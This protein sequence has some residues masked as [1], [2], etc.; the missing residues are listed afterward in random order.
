M[1]THTGSQ[2]HSVRR[3]F[4][5][6]FA[7]IFPGI[8][9]WLYF[10]ALAEPAG[11]P[12]DNTEAS[13]AVVV[14]YSLAK[15][16]QFGFPLIW[17]WYFDRES[18]RALG[19]STRG[20][21]TGLAFG[22]VVAGV[23]LIVYF[24]FLRGGALLE[25][26][27]VL[28]REKLRQFGAATPARYLFLALFLSSVHSLMEEYYWRWFVFGELK[29]V[30]SLAPAL[31][32]SSLAFMAHHVIVLAVYF[33]ANLL[34]AAIPFSLCVAFGGGVWAWIYDRSGSLYSI[35]LSHLLADAGIMAVGYDMVFIFR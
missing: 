16:V 4:V 17:L 29:R 30:V 32:L 33:P 8:M 13:H 20:L 28:V 18:F 12:S 14:V 22:L 7:M 11:G 5:L 15:V 31:I 3:W 10:V 26:T 2:A 9:A 25:R 21:G 27:P 35:W 1:M 6:I 19:L 23:I 34:T 24:G